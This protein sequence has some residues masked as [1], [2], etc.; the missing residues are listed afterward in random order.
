MLV[1]QGDLV[2]TSFLTG[3][4]LQTIDGR[5]RGWE[6]TLYFLVHVVTPKSAA[7][8]KQIIR[9]NELRAVSNA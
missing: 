9:L 8:T 2:R 5:S 6:P 7:G 4:V 1:K 3:T